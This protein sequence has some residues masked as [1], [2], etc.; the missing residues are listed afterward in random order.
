MKATTVLL[1]GAA[2]VGAGLWWMSRATP[3]APPLAQRPAAPAQG[4]DTAASWVQTGADAA[5]A[6][7]DLVTAVRGGGGFRNDYDAS[8]T[9]A[10]AATLSSDYWA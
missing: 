5:R 3:K 4:N 7:T 10:P 1:I 9:G 6:V 2:V 8:D